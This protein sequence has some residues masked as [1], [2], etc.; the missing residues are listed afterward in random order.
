[1]AQ[2]LAWYPLIN[3]TH[4]QG[5]LHLPVTTTGTAVWETGII[6]G[7]ITSASDSAYTI[8][9]WTASQAAQVYNNTS[10]TIAFWV[11]VNAD[12]GTALSHPE[13]IGNN[14]M[15]ATANRKF[16]LFLY[17]NCNSLHWSW[18]NDTANQT[19]AGGTLA[20][21]IPSYTWTHVCVTYD[22]PNG[23]IYING[24][25][26]QSFTGVSNSSSFAYDTDMVKVNSQVRIC[27]L[28][29]YREALSD[30]EV[31]NI[32]RGLVLH[33]PL[34]REGFGQ[35]N[36]LKESD[37]LYKP[38]NTWAGITCTYNGSGW[39]SISGT[40]SNT[41][42][43][44]R[45][46]YGDGFSTSIINSPGT[47]TFSFNDENVILAGSFYWQVAYTNTSGTNTYAY[48]QN[49]GNQTLT[50]TVNAINSIRL[51]VH[52]NASGKTVN[53]RIRVK[54]ES[55]TVSTPWTP[56]STDI[57][58]TSMAVDT[59]VH[60]VSG[61]QHNG[62]NYGTVAYS[63]DTPRHG[64]S[65]QFNG[66]NNWITTGKRMDYITQ[67]VTLAFWAKA[68]NWSSLVG[69]PV[70][71]IE[72]G[73]WGLQKNA[74]TK[75]YMEIAT[76]TSSNTWIAYNLDTSGFAAG[77][78]HFA[79]T[80]DGFVFKCYVDATEKYSVTKYT[81]KTPIY[82]NTNTNA[83]ALFIGGEC[84]GSLNTPTDHFAG[85]V[86]D[87]RVYATALSTAEIQDIYEGVM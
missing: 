52:A 46:L 60:D 79:I 16:S 22:N 63:V 7:S 70:S 51:Y 75:M 10:I 84:G 27:D 82:Y 68:D 33:Y 15:G 17:N 73:G 40:A 3:D 67:E 69:S 81:A 23:K 11:Y 12:T 74:A 35:D 85:K 57:L 77:W 65:R 29:F 34:S 83:N 36:L 43:G 25:L 14:A 49:T 47:Y 1:M 50:L 28:R 64:V 45:G 78:H 58:Y 32:A 30:D 86:S 18:M 20:N 26:K 80:Y 71:C 54:C 56:N 39:F 48:V 61:F 38:S 42:A 37:L 9:R 31:K 6:G 66:S 41:A 4:D 21:V 13:I 72:G 5:T 87:V 59:L 2:L 24:V 62:T 76:G 55:G 8:L 53:G 19:Y 44:I